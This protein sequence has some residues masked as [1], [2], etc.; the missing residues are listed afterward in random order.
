MLNKGFH[1]CS[2]KFTRSIIE[3]NIP[4][5]YGVLIDTDYGKSKI[6]TALSEYEEL[7]NKHF[8][9]DVE[10]ELIKTFPIK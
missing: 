9:D 8:A 3:S 7:I 6:N 10:V 5:Y 1:L 4:C 2:S